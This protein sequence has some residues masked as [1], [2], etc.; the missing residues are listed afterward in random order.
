M[1]V[2]APGIVGYG[3]GERFGPLP[4]TMEAVPRALQ[5]LAG[6]PAEV[7]GP[8]RPPRHVM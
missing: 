5:V 6:R 1:T 4:M 2:A 8:A 3:D 7:P